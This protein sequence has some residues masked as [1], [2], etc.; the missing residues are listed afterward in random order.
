MCVTQPESYV[1]TQRKLFENTKSPLLGCP[2]HGIAM[3][4]PKETEMDSNEN[5]RSNTQ[6]E[7]IVLGVASVETKGNPPVSNESTGFATMPGIT[8]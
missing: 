2:S 3:T 6:E 1:S 7:V 4:H 8:E 5:I